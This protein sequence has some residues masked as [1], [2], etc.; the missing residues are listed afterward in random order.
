MVVGEMSEHTD[1][2]VIGSGP[3]GY[4]AALRAA[5]LG[6][7]VTLIEKEPNE[8]GGLCLHHG[9]I[10]SKSLIHTANVFWDC[11]H[12]KEQGINVSLAVL[13]FDKTQAF[14]QNVIEKLTG[15]IK[16]LLEKAGVDVIYGK[17]QF[18]KSNE[19]HI[20]QEHDT[21]G[22]TAD[23]IVIATG[24]KENPLPTLPFDGKTILSSKELLNLDQVPVSLA[25]IGSGY[26][27]MEMGHTFQ[28][29]GSRVT[30]IHRSPAILSNMDPQIAEIMQKQLEGFG[31]TFWKNTEIMSGEKNEPGIDLHVQTKEGTEETV[32]FEK[33]LVAIGR[34][35][36]TEGLALET[37]KVKTDEKG[38]IL[39]DNKCQTSDPAIL[40][41][42]DI[43]GEPMLAHRAFYM[44]KIAG[45]VCAGLP[46]AFDA[47]V[48]PGVIYSDPEIAWVGLQE[49]EAIKSGRSIVSGMFPFSASGRSMGANR[50]I[51]FVKIV[52]DP[53]S[54]FVLGGTMI[55]AHAS[56]MIA[57]I[58]LAIEMGAKLEDI[59]GTIHP[60]P[61]YNEAILEAA[62]DALGKCVHLPM[63]KK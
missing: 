31:V 57:E 47:H 19:L 40:A 41:I 18:V 63:K 23:K 2:A 28:K 62:E 39:V 10:P 9:C 20:I 14:K 53:I 43:T 30:I 22:L 51:G 5:H 37:T 36:K 12:S 7:M 46:S 3:G 45:E 27:A 4:V 33:V 61:T 35:P 16:F 60:H 34:S 44:G 32:S 24:A 50:P 52:A 25:I 15:G 6:K 21:M 55:G 8:L 59:S 29:F 13:D 58:G 26:I 11:T 48:C 49:H 1:V 56:D 42:G 38:F 54:H 17:A